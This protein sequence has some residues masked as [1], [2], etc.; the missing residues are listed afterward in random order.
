MPC[1]LPCN[2][3]IIAAFEGKRKGNMEKRSLR[4]GSIVEIYYE[5]KGEKL[6]KQMELLDIW[7]PGLVI[8]IDESDG[9]TKTPA[10]YVDR[11]Y[12]IHAVRYQGRLY[13]GASK[14]VSQILGRLTGTASGIRRRRAPRALPAPFLMCQDMMYSP[15]A[16]LR[17]V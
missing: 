4:F 9:K 3:L 8:T 6:P 7:F 16:C 1:L 14:R 11:E 5:L 15:A 2:D 13:A 12:K 17:E 10:E